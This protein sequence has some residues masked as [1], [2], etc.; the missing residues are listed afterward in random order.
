[1]FEAS[2][3]V[4]SHAYRRTEFNTVSSLSDSLSSVDVVN[5]PRKSQG[6]LTNQKLDLLVDNTLYI[7]WNF[8][9]N[10]QI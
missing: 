5:V 6:N 4:L 7:F 1:M 10:R 3:R 9:Q 2:T 8:L